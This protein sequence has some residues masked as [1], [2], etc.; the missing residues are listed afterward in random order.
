MT[1]SMRVALG[2]LL[3]LSLAGRAAASPDSDLAGLSTREY[4]DYTRDR[5]E[6]LTGEARSGHRLAAKARHDCMP[7]AAPDT[8]GGR[9][10]EILKAAR[11]QSD[12][13][14]REG[15][16]LLVGLQ[17]RLGSVPAW[18]RAANGQLTAATGRTQASAAP[19]GHATGVA[20][21]SV[22]APLPQ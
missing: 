13:I 9:A 3:V 5:F 6:W 11:E 12:R 18:A 10:C 8:D 19:V 22:S 1:V 14:L 16:D 17:Q 4:E 2:L 7:D 20:P 21:A 15:R